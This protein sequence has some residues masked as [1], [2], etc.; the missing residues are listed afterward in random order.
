MNQIQPYDPHS[1][2]LRFSGH[3]VRFAVKQQTVINFCQNIAPPQPTP[4]PPGSR[5]GGEIFFGEGGGRLTE[6]DD[7]DDYLEWMEES[8]DF[9]GECA[10]KLGFKSLQEVA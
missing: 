9:G 10:G 5:G 1:L 7:D 4:L 8:G 3:Q 2:V 6:G